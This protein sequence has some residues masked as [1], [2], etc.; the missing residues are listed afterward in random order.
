MSEE[1][2]SVGALSTATLAAAAL[3]GE[4]A[5]AAH[6]GHGNCANCQAPLSGPFCR[7]CGQQAHIHRSLLHLVEEFVHG[8]FHFEAKGW[9]TIPLLIFR[10]G[11]LTRRYIDGQRKTYVSPLALFLF[12]VFLMFFVASLGS[13]QSEPMRTADAVSGIQALIASRNVA[14]AETKAAVDKATAELE[15]ARKEG[16]DTAELQENLDDAIEDQKNA[17]KVLLRLSEES[18]KLMEAVKAA[19]DAGQP[20][21]AAVPASAGADVETHTADLQSAIDKIARERGVKGS[22]VTW[23]DRLIDK[24]KHKNA[25]HSDFP[26]VDAAIHHAIEN[27]ELALY[28]LKNTTYKYSFMLVPISLPFLWL[29]FFW[30]R[31]VGMFDHAVFVLYSLCFMS[32]LFD[33]VMLAGMAGWSAVAANLAIW[34]PPVHMFV[35]LRSAYGL[36][37]FSALWRTVALTIVAAIVLLLFIVLVLMLSMH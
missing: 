21:E 22:N 3:E 31:G 34:V 35:Q 10:P 29:M 15:A 17:E 7:M 16:K 5:H 33:G 28:K 1:I 36:G 11:V 25:G 4:A 18:A 2:E 26:A 20:A 30:R 13:K 37:T 9:R 14:I 6:E 12:M 24:L 23:T 8:V 27:P 19:K 32:L